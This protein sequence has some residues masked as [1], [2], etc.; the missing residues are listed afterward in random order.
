MK[1]HLPL[2]L[3][4]VFSALSTSHA[5]W[6]AEPANDAFTNTA[7]WDAGVVDHLFNGPSSITT[8]S[9]PATYNIPSG[10]LQFTGASTAAYTI[11]TA[12]GAGTITMNSGGGFTVASTVTTNQVINATLAS[13]AGRNTPLNV[14]FTASGTGGSAIALQGGFTGSQVTAGLSIRADLRG[15]AGGR[16]LLNGVVSDGAGAGNVVLTK[17]GGNVGTW[18]L[19]GLNT[20]SGGTEFSAGSGTLV[21]GHRSAL[22][23]GALRIIGGT[24]AG[25]FVAN[26]DLSGPNAVPNTINYVSLTGTASANATVSFTAGSNTANL[27]SGPAPAVGSV[28]NSGLNRVPYYTMVT[29]ISG[30]TLTLS[31]NAVSTGNITNFQASPYSNGGGGT[32]VIG[33]ANPL[34]F[35]GTQNLTTLW[36]TGAAAIQTFDISNTGLT[37]FS[38][39]LQEQAGSAGI[40]KQGAGTLV[41]SGNNTYTGPTTVTAGQLLI[42]GSTGGDTITVASGATLGGNG[43]LAA[44][45]GGSTLEVNGVLAP[46]S[47]AGILTSNKPVSFNLSSTFAAEINGTTAGAGYGQLAANSTVSIDSTAVFSLTLGYAPAPGDQFALISLASGS[48]A[49]TFSGLPEGGTTSAAFGGNSYDFTASYQGGTGNDFVLT[50]VPEPAVSGFLAGALGLLLRSRRRSA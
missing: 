4:T 2:S 50:A 17:T 27:D 46:G 23:T 40:V 28:L 39:T 41:L 43:I 36:S 37:T 3:I 15:T 30:S 49:G 6:L 38:G 16:G 42:N 14:T 21:L 34:E 44:G 32:T 13:P 8:L 1:H 18:E 35:S 11:G 22:G 19:N 45:S 47:S 31:A 48:I 10:L 26:T 9:V 20:Y 24:G 7:N 33:G 29:G 25:G 12:P 5:Q